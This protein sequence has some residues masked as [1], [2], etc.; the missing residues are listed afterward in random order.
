LDNNTNTTFT[1]NDL[2][3]GMIKMLFTRILAI[4]IG[5]LVLGGRKRWPI[6]EELI[7]TTKP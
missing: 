2:H 5:I 6:T 3:P 1:N 4:M 7:S